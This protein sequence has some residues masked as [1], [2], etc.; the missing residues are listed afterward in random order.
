MNI[1]EDVLVTPKFTGEELAVIEHVVA[2]LVGGDV[3]ADIQYF[4][5]EILDKIKEFADGQKS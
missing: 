1:P 3:P 2:K 5:I 4:A